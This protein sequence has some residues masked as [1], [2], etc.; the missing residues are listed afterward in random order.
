MILD[1]SQPVNGT[2]IVVFPDFP[3]ESIPLQ[4]S[5]IKQTIV[6]SAS[7]ATSSSHGASAD[8]PE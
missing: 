3:F 1:Y 6:L 2:G 4:P 5:E 8:L 7:S